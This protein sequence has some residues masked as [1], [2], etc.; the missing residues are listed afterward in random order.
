M[1]SKDN[2][3]TS[4]LYEFLLIMT[5]N[6]KSSVAIDELVTQLPRCITISNYIRPDRLATFSANE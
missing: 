6:A 2:L 4:L 1:F 3:T 5:L